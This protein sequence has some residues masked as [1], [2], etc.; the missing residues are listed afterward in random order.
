MGYS[1]TASKDR[2]LRS[3]IYPGW[4]SVLLSFLILL[5]GTGPVLYGFGV[6]ADRFSV[7]FAASRTSI[8]LILTLATL[9]SGL[10][11]IPIAWLFRRYSFRT[12]VLAGL[13]G[14]FVGLVLASGAQS[15]N[16]I[17]VTYGIIV[18][19]ADAILGIQVINMLVVHWFERRRGMA[20]AIAVSSASVA[21][22]IFPPLTTALVSSF[23]WRISLLAYAVCLIP[24]MCLAWKFAVLPAAVPAIEQTGSPADH[25]AQPLLKIVCC[26]NFWAMS[27]AIG[28]I[29]SANI[30]M[31]SSVVANARSIG[32]GAMA[33]ASLL[34][35][36]GLV[37][38]SGKIVF[39]FLGDRINLRW[40]LFG[41]STSGVAGMA[42]LAFANN[43]VALVAGTVF[44]GLCVGGAMPLLGMIA[45]RSFGL[46]NYAMVLGASRTAMTP[47][48]LSG[49]L[50][51]G[52][53]F[54]RFGSWRPAFLVLLVFLLI[55]AAAS[56]TL[57]IANARDD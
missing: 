19:V 43:A 21:S 25:P 45:A 1:W 38:L 53:M 57:R 10:A 28:V 56:L 35:L 6:F 50:M 23:G 17:I 44:F 40:C 7:E 42:L 29:F 24:L 47:L 39:G 46:A 9:P 52:A 18:G 12:V 55:A 49:P 20:I 27:I 30:A 5:L 36:Q 3:K 22:I 48:M 2:P 37:A 16:A 14:Q 32:L 15:I 33:A 41:A 4:W 31:L 11:G 8:N 34:S 54:D 51:A 13:I 26:R